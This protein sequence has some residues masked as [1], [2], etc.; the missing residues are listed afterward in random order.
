MHMHHMYALMRT[1]AI[2]TLCARPT[3]DCKG[4]C[5]GHPAVRGVTG[6]Q[7]WYAVVMHC[8]V[9]VCA[10]SSMQCAVHLLCWVLWTYCNIHYYILPQRSLH[11]HTMSFSVD[12]RLLCAKRLP[13]PSLQVR[14]GR[15]IHWT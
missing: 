7:I 1:S 6:G 14:Q 13:L 3:G 10:L 15:I 9:C 2:V 4:C 11:I 8:G 12:C 5:H